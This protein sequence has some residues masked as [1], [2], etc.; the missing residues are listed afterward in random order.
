M[1]AF[2]EAVDWPTAITNALLIGIMVELAQINGK[3]DR[4]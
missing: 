1:G 3:L 4:K 2:L